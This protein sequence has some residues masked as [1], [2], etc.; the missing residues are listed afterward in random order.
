MIYQTD[1]IQEVIGRVI[2]NT[3]VQ[4]TSYILAMDEWIPEAMGLMHTK[5]VLSNRWEDIDI[6]F[7]K[8]LLPRGTKIVKA[9][10]H[11]GHRI[12]QGNS[13]KTVD[14]PPEH[15]QRHPA[16]LGTTNAFEFIPQFYDAPPQT[17][18]QEN[19]I[20]Y[21]YDLKSLD[22]EQC[23]G[24]SCDHKAWYDI[25]PGYIL[26]SFKTGRLRIHYKS[27]PLDE[28]GMP[29]IPDNEDY[30]QALY[31]YCRAMMIG[32]GWEDR[33]FSYDKIMAPGIPWNQGTGHFTNYAARAVS[34]IRYPSVDQMEFRWNAHERLIKDDQ[35]F[36]KFFS[37]PHKEEKYG[38][39][40][41]DSNQAPS[42]GKTFINPPH[43]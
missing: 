4:D 24:L 16:P 27:I 3:R 18:P 38:F 42:G 14:A 34:S 19:S 15:H 13:V 37:T 23:N 21:T 33:V 6:H 28:D 26:T 32:A 8:G 10:E 5:T 35:Y 30:K 36:N 31:F 1:S 17:N 43:F 29:L 9:V 41:I 25:E 7:H 11:N 39:W 12:P 40:D 20:I 2:R 22:A